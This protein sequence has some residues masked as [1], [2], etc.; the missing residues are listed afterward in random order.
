MAF[1]QKCGAF[2]P[3]G[4]TLC[5][6]CVK[7]MADA[8]DVPHA[9]TDEEATAPAADATAVEADAPAE[10]AAEAP[11]A[12]HFQPDF[13]AAP[14]PVYTPPKQTSFSLP[15]GD[16]DVPA[17]YKPLGAWTYFLYALLFS[18]PLVGLVSL[19]V[20]SC[21][22]ATNINLR[23]YARSYFCGMLVALILVAIGVGLSIGFGWNVSEM[24][25]E[26]R[27]YYFY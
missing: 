1:C 7:S 21:G 20:L 5:A 8:Q 9:T 12:P 14:A 24:A 2:V 22:G 27:S 17:E 15:T 3:D 10:N 11:R 19:I 23:N 4:E 25:R 13:S 16:G 18:V 26:I 6:A